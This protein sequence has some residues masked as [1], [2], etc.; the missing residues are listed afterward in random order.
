M[1][2]NQVASILPRGLGI[3]VSD[4]HPSRIKLARKLQHFLVAHIGTGIQGFGLPNILGRKGLMIYRSANSIEAGGKTFQRIISKDPLANGNV[5]VM[6]DVLPIYDHPNHKEN[7][8]ILAKNFSKV[9]IVGL[10]GLDVLTEDG[11]KDARHQME[12]C[13]DLADLA[14]LSET[15]IMTRLI[16]NEIMEHLNGEIWAIQEL[17][18]TRWSAHI[19]PTNEENIHRVRIL[20]NAKVCAQIFLEE[21]PK[22]FRSPSHP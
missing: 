15:T 7:R 3:I 4:N 1:E 9:G 12:I 14:D 2:E 20:T 11:I 18:H 5:K 21:T 16:G 8:D 10:S 22:G 17:V 6:S 19:L 13:Q